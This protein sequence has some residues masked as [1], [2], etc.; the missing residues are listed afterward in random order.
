MQEALDSKTKEI[1][2]ITEITLD[3]KADSIEVTND[4]VVANF[5]TQNADILKDDKSDTQGQPDECDL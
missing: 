1:T 4:G 2:E 3:I 5:S